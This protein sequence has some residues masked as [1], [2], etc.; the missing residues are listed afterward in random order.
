MRDRT[1]FI[2]GTDVSAI[3]GANKWRTEFTVWQ[4]KCGN[5]TPIPENAPMEWGIRSEPMIAAKYCEMHDLMIATDVA[6]ELL[7]PKY[8]C[9]GGTVDRWLVDSTGKLYG[10]EIKTAQSDA[11]WTATEVPMH[12]WMQCQWYNG[13]AKA[14]GY[15]VDEWHLAVLFRGVEYREYTIPF[16]AQWFDETLGYCIGWWSTHVVDGSPVS[17]DGSDAARAFQ[18]QKFE[19]KES[20]LVLASDTLPM[21]DRDL[22]THYLHL[23]KQTIM[24]DITLST[25]ETQIMGIIGENKGVSDASGATI[26][27]VRSKPSKSI[28]WSEVA[29][30]ANASEELIGKFTKE[31]A[32]SSYLKISGLEQ[33]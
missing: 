19:A 14:C 9:I 4:E 7:H 25:M 27:W 1:K 16:D 20:A 23:K 5:G 31:K 22:I 8:L 24:N 33:E 26:T 18:R 13:I 12:Y 11:D 30:A 21:V 28:A 15:D 17:L 6:Q 3:L 10:L 2:G 29:K 32:G